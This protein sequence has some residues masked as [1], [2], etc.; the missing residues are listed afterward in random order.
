MTRVMGRVHFVASDYCYEKELA[1]A[2][3]RHRGGGVRLIPVLVEPTDFSRT[4]F[5]MFQC[6]PHDARP[7]STWPNQGA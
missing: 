7:V 4:Q 1:L 2:L 6:L 5:S 3:D